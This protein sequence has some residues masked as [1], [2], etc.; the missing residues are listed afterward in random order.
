MTNTITLTR[1]LSELSLLD[2]KIKK[3]I[4]FVAVKV[5]KPGSPVP[6]E[7]TKEAK[8]NYQSVKDLIIQRDKIKRALVLANANTQVQVAEKSYTI[9]EAI[10]RKSSISYEKDL[11]KLLKQQLAKAKADVEVTNNNLT[12]RLDALVSQ[13]LGSEKKDTAEALSFRQVF[14]EKEEAVLV[15]PLNLDVNLDKMENEIEAFEAEVDNALSEINA[16]TRIDIG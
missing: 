11:L 6:E 14:R 5:K 10:E 7:F 15:D 16:V 1:A 9:A 8:A 4:S 2:K 12:T 3:A 13:Y